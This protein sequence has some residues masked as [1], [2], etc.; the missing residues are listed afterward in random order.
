[1]STHLTGLSKH[2]LEGL[3]D[4]IYAV[5]MTLLVLEL[6]LPPEAGHALTNAD[7][8]AALVELTPKFA[9]WLISFFVLAI[10]WFSHQRAMHYVRSVDAGLLWINVFSL[11]F[12]SL[13]PFSSALVGEHGN[14]FLPQ[15]FYAANMAAMS[16]L[17]IAQVGHLV[18]RPSLCIDGGFP[19]AVAAG[20]R[21]RCWGLVAVAGLAVAIAAVDPRFGTAAFM[22][23]GPLGRLGRRKQDRLA[24]PPGSSPSMEHPPS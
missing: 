5:A 20:A 4:G 15:A 7:L 13:L 8:G 21:F 1:M 16:L 12:A 22:L 10:F 24:A 6:K 19:D 2:R 18:R 23:M 17:A 14:L 11:L 9:A 3:T